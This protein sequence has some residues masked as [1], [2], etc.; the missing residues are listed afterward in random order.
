V[1][2]VNTPSQA[3]TRPVRRREYAA[4][5]VILAAS[6]AL[7]YAWHHHV[8]APHLG[9]T[10]DEPHYVMIAHSLATDRDLDLGNNYA[11]G[12]ADAWFP[13]LDAGQHVVDYRGDGRLLSVHT[14][15]LPLLLLPAHV[16]LDNPTRA[17]RGTMLGITVLMLLEFYLL[18]LDITPSRWFAVAAW[19]VMATSVPTLYLAG[20]V[21]PDVAAALVML[22]GLRALWRLPSWR[23]MGVLALAVA[24]FPWLHVRFVPL[25]V[26]LGLAGF[27]RLHTSGQRVMGRAL[28]LLCLVAAGGYVWFYTAH[29]GNPLGNAQYAYLSPRPVD[30]ARVPRLLMGL[31]WER[32]IGIL[33]VVP[34]LVLCISGCMSSLVR[35]D[36]RGM[37]LVILGA[38][39]MLVTTLALATGVADWGWSMPWRF[40][41]PVYPLMGLLALSEIAR[42]GLQR[43]IAVPLVIAGLTVAMLS[44]RWP[45]GFYWRNAGVLGMPG[46]DRVQQYLPS[47]SY[48]RRHEVDG[49]AGVTTTRK[50]P[51]K[52][53]GE[54][55]AIAG[56]DVAGFLSWGVRKGMLPGEMAVTFL[57]RGA[58]GP[59]GA[60]PGQVRVVDERT[61]QTIL[62]QDLTAANLAGGG[63]TRITLT[64]ASDRARVVMAPVT[65]SGAGELC[66]EKV[67]FEQTVLAV[68]DWGYLPAVLAT[69]GFC[70]LGLVQ[71]RRDRGASRQRASNT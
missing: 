23:W 68:R 22:V 3:D 8:I 45:D 35:R 29:Y 17:A 55:C 31:L 59:S 52:T 28:V 38:A 62:A 41:F 19:L 11:R 15:G 54:V 50:G 1:A 27:L 66:L 34:C 53:R 58:T 69:V 21:Y 48:A 6:L 63:S 40:M 42:H 10:G 60:S 12:D 32:E 14:P 4:V 43:W 71:G 25:A 46:L 24:Y 49:A 65:Y 30:W 57:V 47:D 33:P 70:L 16:L 51:D 26:L 61:D 64:L 18:C 67:I 9:L 39:Y 44:M 37:L 56:H 36:R 5:A 13:D 7:V 2:A 20:Q